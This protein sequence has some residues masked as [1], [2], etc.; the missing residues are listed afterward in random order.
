MSRR[1]TTAQALVAYLAAQGV[2][3]DGERTPFF[4][5]IFGIFGHGNVAGIG[6]AI[7]QDGRLR[8]I[9]PRNEQAA[10]HA[11]IAHAKVRNRLQAWAVTSSIGPGATNLVTGAATATINRLPVLLLPG[12]L[13][14]SRRPDPV[15]QQLEAAWSRTA[16]VNDALKPVSRYWDTIQRPGQLVSA[17]HEAM[18]VLTDPAETGAVTICLPQDVAPEAH[19]WPEELFAER[20]WTIPRPRPDSDLLQRAAAAIRRARRPLIVAGGGAI[21]AGAGETLAA[22]AAATGIP[23][24]STMAGLGALRHDHPQA[25]G[26][27]GVT[28]TLAANR[29]AREADLVLGIGTRWTDFT[30]AS[31]TAFQ[32]P[33]VE[34]VSVNVDARDASKQAG[35]PLTGD[36]RVVLEELSAALAT[37]HVEDGYA[38]GIRG[39]RADWER[40][41]VR[42]YGLEGGGL[43]A[44]SAIIG[45]IEEHCGEEGIVVC[46]AGSLPGEL[47]KLWRPR[48][49]KAFHLE[50]GYSC[51]GYEVAGGV[52]AALA[53]PDREIVV[54]VGDGSWLLMSSELATAVQEDLDLT[55][56]LIES[57]GYASIGSLSRSVGSAGFGTSYRGRDGERLPIDL[58][59]NAGSLGATARRARSLAELRSELAVARARH[60]VD[61]IVI[62]RS[63]EHAVPDYDSW[64][65]VPPAEVS[66]QAA[67]RA[68]RAA[69][70][71]RR[72][73]QRTFP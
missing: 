11:A 24:A 55:V 25:L 20:T 6:Q 17:L 49:P 63:M 3:R 48:H 4:A 60:G 27:V 66:E 58:V 22:F 73:A 61:V 41:V 23:V 35:L 12:D 31:Q 1:L 34:F 51:M 2:E 9:V 52:G 36:A 19:D 46:A 71:E 39:L 26:A 45:A 50:Y 18:R 30:T 7:D 54:A 62:E 40:E 53:A 32:D 44:Q 21:Y 70:E 8:F 33:S 28:G 5:G 65:E 67:V 56:V 13:F 68:A 37:H 43:P 14:A 57:H 64:W 10:V 42:L 16:S 29:I 38:S 59:A 47:H 72:R 15:L 69:Y